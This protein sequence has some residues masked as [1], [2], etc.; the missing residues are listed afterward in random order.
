M[1]VFF[2]AFHKHVVHI[3]LDVPPDLLNEYP[4]LK[5][6]IYHPRVLQSERYDLVTEEPLTHDE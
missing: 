1:A 2:C 3:Y 6:L 5:S 4:V